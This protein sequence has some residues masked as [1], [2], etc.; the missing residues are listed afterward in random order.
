MTAFLGFIISKD[1][2]FYLLSI[3][4]I[5][6]KL[7]AEFTGIAKTSKYG[8]YKIIPGSLTDFSP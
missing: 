6:L 5:I 7:K 2:C 4:S 8:V 3:E 1:I